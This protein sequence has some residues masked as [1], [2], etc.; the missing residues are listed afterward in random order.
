MPDALRDATLRQLSATEAAW[1][2]RRLAYFGG[3]D[4]LR[5]AWHPRVRAAVAEAA[6]R[7]GHNVAASRL[8]TGNHPLHAALERRA[9]GGSPW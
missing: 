1:R 7:E 3:S 6:A 4:Y 8:T 2:G 9:A 5:L